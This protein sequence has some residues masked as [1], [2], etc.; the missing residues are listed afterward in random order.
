V[1]FRSKLSN[2]SN[3]QAAYT[4]SHTIADFEQ[5]AANG[6][7][8]QG[9]FTD[10]QNIG[11]D[12]GNATINRP[13]IFVF[14]EVFFLPKFAHQASF[15]RE[16]VGGW[17]STLSL[18]PKA[19]NSITVYQSGLAP[20]GTTPTALVDPA[21]PPPQCSGGGLTFPCA[22]LASLSGTGFNNTQRP[23][24]VPGTGCNSVRELFH[25]GAAPRRPWAG[26]DHPGTTL[27]AAQLG[28]E[29]RCFI[30]FR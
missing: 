14:N 30:T 4:W 18:R 9:S 21:A 2:F 10:I 25:P 29:K 20:A 16:S 6:G 17:N 19:A 24:T 15:I 23:N 5:D 27:C 8:S 7:G 28:K 11:A 3:I 13:H 22:G 1:L 26:Q 12:R